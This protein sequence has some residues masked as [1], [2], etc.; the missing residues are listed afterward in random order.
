M[1]C[2]RVSIVGAAFLLAV[3]GVA[4]LSCGSSPP[5]DEREVLVLCGGS[6][7]AALE[8][9][10]TEYEKTSSDTILTSYGDSGTLCAQI[11]ET[12][13]GDVYICHDPFMPWADERGLIARWDTLAQL[14]P[15]IVVPSGNPKAVKGL[16]DLAQP[17]LRLGIGEQTFSTSGQIV[18]QILNAHPRGA[19]VRANVRLETK[20]HQQRCND[21]T[22]GTLDAAI[23]WDAVASLYADRLAAIPIP[24]DGVDAITSA[25]YKRSDVSYVKVTAGI[26]AGAEHR[27]ATQRFFRYLTEHGPAA[28]VAAGFSA[29]RDDR[30]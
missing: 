20:G 22:M 18:K 27:A 23:V 6:M 24:V 7:R 15:V 9:V 2:A 8:R 25:T 17:G 5:R 1:T 30:P 28:F 12:G 21:V 16:D 10:K 19:E 14:K 26:V 13:R 11:R 29:R 4:A 3:A